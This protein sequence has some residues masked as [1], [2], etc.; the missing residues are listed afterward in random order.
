MTQSS[1][2]LIS[3]HAERIRRVETSEQL[4]LLLLLLLTFN[5]AASDSQKKLGLN[6]EFY[7][8]HKFSMGSFQIC[9]R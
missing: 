5:A 7:I 4:L 1:P 2:A 3:S 8:F 6:A 9:W